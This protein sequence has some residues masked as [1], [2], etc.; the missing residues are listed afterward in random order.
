MSFPTKEQ[1]RVI[2]HSGKPL[3]VVAAPGTGKTR[4][5]VTRMIKLLKENPDRDV[6]FITFTRSSRRDTRRCGDSF[7]RGIVP[8]S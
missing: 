3:I 8:N 7:P 2:N 4:T 6:S 1:E 5:I